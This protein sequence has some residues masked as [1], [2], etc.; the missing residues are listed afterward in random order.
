MQILIT[1]GTG[2]IG[3]RLV[4]KLLSKGHRMTVLSRQDAKEVRR[5]LTSEVKPVKSLSAVNPSIAYDAVINLAGEGVMDERWTPSRKRQLLESRVT[6]TSELVDLIERMENRPRCLIS[7]S[8]IGFYGGRDDATRL[9]ESSDPGDDFA[10][11][12]CVRWEQAA[13]RAEGLDV[14]VCLVRTSVVLHPE[15]G[16]M[17][18]MLPPFRLGIGGPLG[19]GKQMM[20]W[21][22]MDDM[23]N[24]LL[25][26]L[27]KE[28]VQ[29]IF[30]ATAPKAVSNKEYSKALAASLN[31]PAFLTMPAMILKLLLGESSEMVL[32]GQ[33]VYPERLLAEGFQ[34]TYPQLQPALTQLIDA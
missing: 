17:H 10:A 9:D 32:K 14:K 23:V 15:G 34:F 1:G 8:A 11:G 2:F 21:I 19:S 24:A 31:R 6:L 22:H 13:K 3:R 7:G 33:N 28:S 29:G 18:E 30:N 26:L 27:E 5:L 16:A 4:A 25:F 20:S 12:L